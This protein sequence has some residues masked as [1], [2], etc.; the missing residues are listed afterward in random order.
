MTRIEKLT[1]ALCAE[2]ETM[3]TDARVA[4]LNDVRRALHEVSPFESH[5]V[6]LVL[7]V[8]AD[9][10]VSNAENPNKVAAPEMAALHES[11]K[12][13]GFTMPVYAAEFDATE[14]RTVNG[15]TGDYK[16][17]DGHH[18]GQI[19]KKHKDVAKSTH[20]YQPITLAKPK[21]LADHLYEMWLHNEA[22]GKWN[23]ERSVDLVATISE[24]GEKPHRMAKKLNMEA[25][26]LIRMKA[27]TGIAASYAK[28]PFSRSWVAVEGDGTMDDERED[29]RA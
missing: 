20:G 27:Q 15:K 2:L 17:I 4:A 19:V 5:P 28:E 13:S 1:K 23:E 10:V 21:A 8:H 11:I 29:G 22:R 18:R 25:E 24:L 12:Q 16:V 7:W 26:R 14:L 6:D 3:D 9:R